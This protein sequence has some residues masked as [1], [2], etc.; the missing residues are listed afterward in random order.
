MAVNK[1]LIGAGATAAAGGLTPSEHFGV[2]SYEGDG[3]SGRS[4]NGGK[5]GAGVSFGIDKSTT[6]ATDSRVTTT[7]YAKNVGSISGW[8]KKNGNTS[9]LEYVFVTKNDTGSAHQLGINLLQES[10]IL[11]TFLA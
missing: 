3:K 7:Y 5:Y 8:L 11:P 4:V 6:Q 9:E 10:D 2:V 1:R